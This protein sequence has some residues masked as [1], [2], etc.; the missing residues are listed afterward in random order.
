MG[1]RRSD[2]SDASDA[3]AATVAMRKTPASD[4]GTDAT[5]SSDG[6]PPA[7]PGP[8]AFARDWQER[9]RYALVSELARG[10]GG[11]IAVAVDRKLGRKVALKRPLDRDGEERLE[12]EA[13]VLARLEHPAIVPIHD[14]GHDGEGNPYYTMKLLGGATLA[15]WIA[16]AKTFEQRLALLPAVITVADAVAYAHGQHVI[17]RDLKPGN[18]LVGEFGEVALID[19]GL[20]KIIGDTEAAAS[21]G[22]LVS[23]ELTGHGAVVGTPAYMAPEQAL[24]EDLDERADVYA[25]GAMLYHVLTGDVPYGRV[26]TQQTLIELTAGPPPPI[27]EREPRVPPDLAA[28]VATAMARAPA[29]RYRT[30]NE[31]ALDLH[32]YQTG[33]LVAAHRYKLRTRAWRWARRHVAAIAAGVAVVAVGVAGVAIVRGGAAPPDETCVGLDAPV[34]AAWNADVRA[35]IERAFTATGLPDAAAAFRS[36]ASALDQQ[37]DRIGAMRSEACRATRVT[38]AQTPEVMDLRMQCLDRR[39]GELRVLA[40]VLASADATVVEHAGAALGE[41]GRVEDCADVARLKDG[42]PLPDDARRRDEILAVQAE[43]DRLNALAYAGKYASMFGGTFP[44]T[45]RALGTGFPPVITRAYIREAGVLADAGADATSLALYR[46]AI[47]MADRAREDG[48]RGRALDG[49]IRV[50]LDHLNQL[51]PAEQAARDA[52]AVA[53]RTGDENLA[54][55]V[56]IYM[57]HIAAAR[58]Q[59]GDAE[60]WDERALAIQRRL[61]GPLLDRALYDL[62]SEYAEEGKWDEAAALL[63]EAIAVMEKAYGTD[64]H[65]D[66]GS[67]MTNLAAVLDGKGDHAGAIATQRRVIEILAQ[68]LPPGAPGRLDAQQNLATMLDEAGQHADAERELR[69]VLAIAEQKLGHD[70]PTCVQIT[71]GLGE[72]LRSEHRWDDAIAAFR[73]SQARAAAGDPNSPDV[74]RARSAVGGVDVQ[75]ERYREAVAELAPALAIEDKAAPDALDTALTRSDLGRAQVGLGE[76]RAG[77]AS[78]RA[79]LRVIDADGNPVQQALTRTALAI[80]LWQLG[81]H[82]D[83]RAVAAEARAEIDRAGA[84]AAEERDEL[85]AWEKRLPPK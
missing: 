30:A 39:T 19:W 80:G 40:G 73:D 23:A 12:R 74:A 49:V 37:A 25:L 7:P 10:G 82:D 53:D 42:M 27:D 62:G 35:A 45:M 6:A 32:R 72:A 63:R 71:F 26:S 69:S 3:A 5:L 46:L 29:E 31:L 13:L 1:S 34:R 57:S 4:A 14:A 60:M 9:G 70:H 66:I 11:R 65:P 81:Q 64:V 61:D 67:A 21:S 54:S 84:A 52:L 51:D 43:L 78:L 47:A 8:R 55:E 50:E 20:G 15:D 48:Q 18:V 77:E 41:L 76:L 56:D 24:G 83:A 22:E 17:H 28:I 2:A 33:K 16:E 68:L 75:R 38:G 44:A 59:P 36:T 85:D 58:K 79:A